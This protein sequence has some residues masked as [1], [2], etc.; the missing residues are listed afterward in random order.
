MVIV[1]VFHLFLAHVCSSGLDFCIRGGWS[2]V[3]TQN[4]AEILQESGVKRELVDPAVFG[5]T[6]PPPPQP[7]LATT[8]T[9]QPPPQTMPP[10]Q[11]DAGAMNKMVQDA[12]DALATAQQMQVQLQ[13]QLAAAAAAGVQPAVAPAPPPEQ[14]LLPNDDAPPSPSPASPSPEASPTM[15][16]KPARVNCDNVGDSPALAQIQMPAGIPAQRFESR[17]ARKRE[18]SKYMRSLQ[19]AKL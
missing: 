1:F 19:P 17:N 10:L 6:A 5:T 18:W 3:M 7:P 15:P 2:A 16:A 8:A 9:P 13:Q 14:P 12:M 11:P 4:M